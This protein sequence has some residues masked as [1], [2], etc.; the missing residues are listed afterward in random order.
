MKIRVP[1]SIDLSNKKDYSDIPENIRC[2]LQSTG[3][4]WYLLRAFENEMFIG[5]RLGYVRQPFSGDGH[6]EIAYATRGKGPGFICIYLYDSMCSNNNLVLCSAKVFRDDLL[7]SAVRL[8]ES[9][10]GMV[11]VEVLQYHIGADC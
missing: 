6:V 8:G 1:T 9:L 11:G 4:G 10:A 5:N 7:A 3:P 2:E